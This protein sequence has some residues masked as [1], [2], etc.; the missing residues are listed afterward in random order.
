MERYNEAVTYLNSHPEA[1][2]VLGVLALAVVMAFPWRKVDSEEWLDFIPRM[3]GRRMKRYRR[4]YVDQQA[5]DDFVHAVEER[6]YQ[7]IYTRDEAK[8]LYRKMKQLFPIR[9]L[10]PAPA[11]LKEAIKKRKALAIHEPVP[12]PGADIASAPK[13]AFDKPKKAKAA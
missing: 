8:E 6:V 12:L 4:N 3:K 2:L 1:V 9:D 11:L 7:G 13:H 5:T 10:F